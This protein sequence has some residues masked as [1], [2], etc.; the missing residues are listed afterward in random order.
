MS[1]SG[2]YDARGDGGSADVESEPELAT[3]TGENAWTKFATSSRGRSL[4]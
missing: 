1:R 2:L 4:A 3:A